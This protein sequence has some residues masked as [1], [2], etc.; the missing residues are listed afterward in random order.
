M[1]D[2]T[3]NPGSDQLTAVVKRLHDDVAR[4]TNALDRAEA[5]IDRQRQTILETLNRLEITDQREAKAS[6][7]LDETVMERDRLAADVVALREALR[8]YGNHDDKCA[9]VDTWNEDYPL[10]DCGF[11]IALTGPS[12]AV[13]EIERLVNIGRACTQTEGTTAGRSERTGGRYEH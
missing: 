3:P 13:A 5:T 10:C 6:F 9:M 8:R 12:P 2:Q 4:R 7:K 1:T 11:S